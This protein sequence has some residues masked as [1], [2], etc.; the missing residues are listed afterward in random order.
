MLYT[1]PNPATHHA[2]FGGS[3]FNLSNLGGPDVTIYAGFVAVLVEPPRDR[4]RHRDR[5]RR[6]DHRRRRHDGGRRLPRRSLAHHCLSFQPVLKI[7]QI[8]VR[9]TSRKP[10]G[11]GEADRD[12]DVGDAVEAQRKPEIR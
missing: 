12:V 8:G 11:H 3:A 5:A 9:H 6:E 10:S 4:R 7:H 2:H 1:M